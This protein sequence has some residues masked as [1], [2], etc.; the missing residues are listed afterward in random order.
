MIPN[1]RGRVIFR[2]GLLLFSC[3]ALGQVDQTGG[4]QGPRTW[5]PVGYLGG[6]VGVP[7]EGGVRDIWKTTITISPELV[8]LKL[9]SGRTVLIECRKI[10]TLNYAGR[11]RVNDEAMA[12]G[13]ALFSVAG[14]AVGSTFRSTDHYLGIEYATSDGRPSAVLLQLHKDN[15]KEIIAALGACGKSLGQAKAYPTLASGWWTMWDM[16]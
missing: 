3:L 12:L 14:L 4:T 10:V 16:L 7:R 15:Y 13:G 9:K 8:E 5:R 2:A 6:A 11:R 1:L